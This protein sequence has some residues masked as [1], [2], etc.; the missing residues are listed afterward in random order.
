[1]PGRGRGGG[2]GRGRG[3]GGRGRGR[4]GSKGR[5]G[6][7]GRGGDAEG[8]DG[9]SGPHRRWKTGPSGTRKP[10]KRGRQDASDASKRGE[11]RDGREGGEGGAERGPAAVV[12]DG[13]TP[14]ERLMQSMRKGAAGS[15]GDF[16]SAVGGG[17]GSSEAETGAGSAAVRA[18]MA[19]LQAERLGRD[20][21]D[22]DS[23]EESGASSGT[24][25]GGG[26]GNGHSA[27]DVMGE[28]DG[29]E[30]GATGAG[31][32]AG[33]SGSGGVASGSSGSESDSDSGEEGSSASDDSSSIAD[34][35]G[36]PEE[37][38][39]P[40]G[41]GTSLAD[42][43]FRRRYLPEVPDDDGKLTTDAPTT[44]AADGEAK[45]YAFA[46]RATDTGVDKYAVASVPGSVTAVEWL[47]TSDDV[48]VGATGD[49]TVAGPP[50]VAPSLMKAKVA[51]GWSAARRRRKK[52]AAGE[53]A[54]TVNARFL[55]RTIPATTLQRRLFGVLGKYQDLFFA[56]QSQDNDTQVRD[57]LALHCANHVVKAREAMQK[58]DAKI[59]AARVQ[60]VSR[61][62]EKEVKRRTAKLNA[63]ADAAKAA[64]AESAAANGKPKRRRIASV[65]DTEGDDD[66][67]AATDNGGAGAHEFVE[68][69]DQGFARP[70]VL[71]LAPFRSSAFAFVRSLLRVMPTR[72]VHKRE[73]FVRDFGPPE[74]VEE[75]TADT[76]KTWLASHDS[77]VSDV[78]DDEAAGGAGGGPPR[79][80][81][82]YRHTFRGNIDDAFIFGISVSRKRIRL[83]ADS[84]SSD[85]IVASPVALRRKIGMPGDKEFDADAFSSVEVLV[86]DQVDVLS[87][88]NLDHVQGCLEACNLMPKQTRD[89]DFSRVRTFNLE[90][91]AAKLR[92]SIFL[93]AYVEPQ[94]VALMRRTCH[95][96]A[97]AVLVRG[98][99]GGT[100][101]RVAL[102]VRQVFQRVS[103]TTAEASADERFEFFKSKVMPRLMGAHA[104]VT[105]G[106][107]AAGGQPHTLIFVPTYFDFLR[108]RRLLR[109]KDARFAALSAYAEDSSIARA[110]TRLYHGKIAMMLYTER[111]HFY[112]RFRLRGV[113]HIVWYGPPVHADFYAELLNLLSEAADVAQPVSCLLLFSRFDAAPLARIV[114]NTRAT[115]ML[116]EDR[117]P[118]F[119][120]C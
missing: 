113:R 60:A 3:R 7:K 30:E 69:K 115:R 91:H 79:K 4:G 98:R 97:G 24:E 112:R 96:E 94:A 104:G 84:F 20:S 78:S 109:D 35:A 54:D 39:L 118:T 83:F 103:V 27:E 114:G 12:D 16:V 108:L 5:R 25:S 62:K 80:P 67:A 81:K 6:G 63:E 89:T 8:A 72:E 32:G 52:H 58:H 21:S 17:M 2:R 50:L 111:L 41:D 107:V 22:D 102:Q 87:M 1:M 100:L 73:R 74:R 46:L 31:S 49:K 65:D 40:G 42:D 119:L 117:Q 26:A 55:G 28:G 11:K 47:A 44:A 34:D 29:E 66:A 75:G 9:P 76:G 45:P 57:A 18:A 86:V 101:S 116:E 15:P 110:R 105:S 85:I 37:E 13:L 51:D 61:R 48:P 14:Y 106:D 70:R 93:S 120:F 88:A 92:Q 90:G 38:P 56:L 71:V 53:L 23:G 10:F 59:N 36:V 95:N 82:D 99:Y 68:Y 43:I 77:D 33:S 64:A 19:R